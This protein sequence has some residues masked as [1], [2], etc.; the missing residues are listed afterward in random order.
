LIKSTSRGFGIRQM[1]FANAR[2]FDV[3]PML[4]QQAG[5]VTIRRERKNTT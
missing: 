1:L 2:F 4:Q 3:R 5:D